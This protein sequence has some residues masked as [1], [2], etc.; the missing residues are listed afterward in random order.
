MKNKNSCDVITPSG[1]EKIDASSWH[2]EE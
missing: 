1:K 2:C